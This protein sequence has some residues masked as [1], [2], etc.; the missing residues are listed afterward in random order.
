MS[1]TQTQWVRQLSHADGEVSVSGLSLVPEDPPE[2]VVEG[3]GGTFAATAVPIEP[4]SVWQNCLN[5]SGSML[6][7]MRVVV[8][9]VLMS[10]ERGS[11]CDIPNCKIRVR[12]S[13]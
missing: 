4:A 11:E 9:V 6:W 3:A 2:G 1:P 12:I 13:D 8:G 7:L 5:W 10:L